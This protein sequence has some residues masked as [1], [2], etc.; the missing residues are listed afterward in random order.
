MECDSGDDRGE[1]PTG[2]NYRA[3]GWTHPHPPRPRSF[4]L[5]PHLRPVRT[6]EFI[7][8]AVCYIDIHQHE[9]R[10]KAR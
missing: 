7:R 8:K 10:G 2:A 4:S 6:Q 9:E 1:E 3:E 5:V